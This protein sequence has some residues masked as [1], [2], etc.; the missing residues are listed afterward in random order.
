[1][2]IHVFQEDLAEGHGG[3]EMLHWMYDDLVIRT[4]G[5][6]GDFIWIPDR[7][8]LELKCEISYSATIPSLQA[9]RDFRTALSIKPPKAGWTRTDNLFVEKYS[10]EAD[11]SVGG[12]WQAQ[13][14]GA[15]YYVHFFFGDGSIFA[16]RTDEMVDFMNKNEGRYRLCPVRNEGY[17]TMGHPVPR[18]D[19]ARLEIR[20][21]F[22]AW[23]PAVA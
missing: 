8:V 4:D 7:K 20:G 3:E 10:S 2:K 11:E 23:V 13:K 14:H 12:P 9:A 19:V 18:A 1:M 17:T 22:P 6:R 21:M 16:Y 15:E 5:K